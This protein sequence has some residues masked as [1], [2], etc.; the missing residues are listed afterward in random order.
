[1][2]SDAMVTTTVLALIA[3]PIAG[4]LGLVIAWLITRKLRRGRGLI[5]FLGMLGLAVPGTVLG[6]GYAL[7]FNKDLG[8]GNT[9]I[10]PALAGGG[11]I[12]G[13][14]IAIVMVYIIRSSPQGQRSGVAALQQIDMAIDE[15]SASL[16][17]NGVTTFRKITLP[18]VSP[19]LL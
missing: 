19:A 14:A 5:D 3:T 16:G 12:A 18:L 4:V 15:A 7:T 2:G 13:G 10:I 17:A 9:V 11:A 6:I 1:I 8:F